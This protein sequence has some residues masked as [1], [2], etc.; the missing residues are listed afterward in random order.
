LAENGIEVSSAEIV[1]QDMAE[2]VRIPIGLMPISEARDLL[3]SLV[4]VHIQEGLPG[5]LNDPE[6]A[7]EC[8]WCPVRTKCEELNGSPVGKPALENVEAAES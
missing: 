5:I 1:Y 4:A 6:E 3:E 8:E 7:W 2:Q